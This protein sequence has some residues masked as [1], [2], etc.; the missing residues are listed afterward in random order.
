MLSDF[1]KFMM[2]GNVM[3]LAIGVVIGGAFTAIVNSL[4]DHIF[5]PIVG[6]LVADIN[7][8]DL[9]IVLSKA[10]VENGEVIKPEAAIG[11]GTLIQT[12]VTFFIIALFLFFLIRG[13][14]RFKKEEV[15]EPAAKPDDVLLL[16]EIRDLL[17]EKDA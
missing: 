2:Q 7:F 10:I 13:M 15:E 14:N 9:K 16:E 8:S 6:V 5:M 11:Y 4:V 12:I 17:K 1:K 3:D